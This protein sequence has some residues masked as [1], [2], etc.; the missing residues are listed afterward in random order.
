MSDIVDFL[1]ARLDDD[2]RIAAD[3]IAG[4]RWRAESNSVWEVD[5]D[6][7]VCRAG[8]AEDAE[9]IARHDPARVLADVAAKRAI[10]ASHRE[11]LVEERDMHE[12]DWP[13][14]QRGRVEQAA[15][16]AKV[17]VLRAAVESLAQPYADHSDFDPAWKTDA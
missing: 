15:A 7:Q 16:A 8:T 13:T 2:E 12:I 14:E 17:G 1:T 10:L 11:A 3:L 6:D 4:P 9:H 5:D